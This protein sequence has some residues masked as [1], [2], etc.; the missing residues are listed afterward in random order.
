MY[1]YEPRL[2]SCAKNLDRTSFS[3]VDTK[4]VDLSQENLEFVS[5]FYKFRLLGKST[6][7][8]LQS[9]IEITLKKVESFI[10]VKQTNL[11]KKIKSSKKANHEL[12]K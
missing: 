12:S 5:D 9:D 1:I 8:A 4:Y 7:E 3:D 10:S 2:A 6:T 11:V